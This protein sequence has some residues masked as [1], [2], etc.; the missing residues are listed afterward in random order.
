[1]MGF[2]RAFAPRIAKLA[3]IGGVA[4][5]AV[6][7]PHVITGAAGV[8]ADTLGVS[9]LLV[10][11]L[12]WGI[13][14]GGGEEKKSFRKRLRDT[15][16]S[17]RSRTRR[18]G[19]T[20]RDCKHHFRFTAQTSISGSCYAENRP[21]KSFAKYSDDALS[22]FC[23]CFA[24][25]FLD[26]FSK[27]QLATFSGYD[28]QQWKQWVSKAKNA[29]HLTR[30][31]QSC[32]RQHPPNAS[33]GWSMR[34]NCLRLSVIRRGNSRLTTSV[35]APGAGAILEKLPFNQASWTGLLSIS[36]H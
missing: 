16:S 30:A 6:Y 27:T 28:E 8:I 2:T 32:M 1:M 19:F 25:K 15:A 33:D 5:L 26:S 14:A 35:L 23:T 13:M 11:T 29:A 22:N 18:G 12:V 21:D 9:P 17:S 34:T 20:F 24:R 10:Q 31:A 3:T 36:T 7:Y 4:Y